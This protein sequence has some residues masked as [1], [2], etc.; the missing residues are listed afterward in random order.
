MFKSLIYSSEK[1]LTTE[2][3][4]K[5]LNA[6]INWSSCSMSFGVK[7]ESLFSVLSRLEKKTS[8]SLRKFIWTYRVAYIHGFNLE[9][10]R[11]WFRLDPRKEIFLRRETH[12]AKRERDAEICSLLR[13]FRFKI[14]WWG[15][16]KIWP[17]SAATARHAVRKKLLRQSRYLDGC[18]TLRQSRRIQSFREKLRN[19]FLKRFYDNNF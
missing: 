10:K 11:F 2:W 13:S 16:R 14:L 5:Q 1:S 19:I 15:G 6:L 12:K 17:G 18:W 9:Q 8:G 3:E 7:W 4:W